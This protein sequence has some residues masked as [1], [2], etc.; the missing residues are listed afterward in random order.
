MRY[1]SFIGIDPLSLKSNYRICLNCHDFLQTIVISLQCM[2]ECSHFTK[3]GVSFSYNE[4][5][6][7]NFDQLTRQNLC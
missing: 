3:Y 1:K 5:I 2:F 4:I 6:P 7:D